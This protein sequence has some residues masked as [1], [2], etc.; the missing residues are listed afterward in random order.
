LVYLQPQALLARDSGELPF[1]STA[2]ELLVDDTSNSFQN[3]LGAWPEAAFAI[4]SHTGILA[5][6]SQ[7]AGP[8]VMGGGVRLSEFSEQLDVF[9]DEFEGEREEERKREN[10]EAALLEVTGNTGR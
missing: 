4:D 6:R 8:E 5:C 2:H 1:L 9:L 10:E 7:L 3:C